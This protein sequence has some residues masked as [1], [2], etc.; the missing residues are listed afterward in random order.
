MVLMLS[1]LSVQAKAKTDKWMLY[2]DPAVPSYEWL[3]TWSEAYSAGSSVS[4]YKVNHIQ[5]GV[6]VKCHI[7][8]TGKSKT[9]KGNGVFSVEVM[10]G[11]VYTYKVSYVEK[12]KYANKVRGTIKH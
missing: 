3:T 4:V 5:S 8:E 2:F 1:P 12:T 6:S 10:R 7:V 11:K 9:F